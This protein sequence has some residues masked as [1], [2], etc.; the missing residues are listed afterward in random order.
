MRD[1]ARAPLVEGPVHEDRRAVEQQPRHAVGVGR[2]ADAAR[3]EVA[4]DGVRGAAVRADQRDAERVEVRVGR[5]P[6]PRRR[7]REPQA[8]ALARV[9][10]RGPVAPTEK[11]VPRAGALPLGDARGA[12]WE[13]FAEGIYAFPPPHMLDFTIRR[14]HQA[15]AILLLV[16][17]SYSVAMWRR[18]LKPGPTGREDHKALR[19]MVTVGAGPSVFKDSTI[20]SRVSVSSSVCRDRADGGRPKKQ[21]RLITAPEHSQTVYLLNFKKFRGELTALRE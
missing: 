8:V 7:E 12:D 14:A 21:E 17:P 18:W 4:A 19:G 6:K 2:N 13:S 11:L 20:P 1:G 5:G 16:A 3:A 15:K 10:P 9:A